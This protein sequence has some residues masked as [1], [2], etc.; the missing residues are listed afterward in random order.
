MQCV[1]HSKHASTVRTLQGTQMQSVPC[2]KQLQ[3]VLRRKQAGTIHTL[4]KT[5]TVHTSEERG[6]YKPYLAGN[7]QLQT[8]L[9]RKQAGTVRTLQGIQIQYLPHRKQAGTARTS[10]ETRRYSPYL[11]GNTRVLSVPDETCLLR[12]PVHWILSY[13]LRLLLDL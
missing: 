4:Q 6:K 10:Q 1:P 5:H 11:A 8:V 13:R 9:L 12:I 7:R 2:R 3:S